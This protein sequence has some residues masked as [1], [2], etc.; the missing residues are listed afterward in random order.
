LG[1]EADKLLLLATDSAAYMIK[2][3]ADVLRALYPHMIHVTC[4]CHAIHRICEEV[5]SRFADVDNLISN[6]KKVFDLNYL[7]NKKIV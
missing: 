6:T 3:A 4:L 7:L 2:A 1:I 5:R